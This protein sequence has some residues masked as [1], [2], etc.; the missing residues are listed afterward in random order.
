MQY[1]DILDETLYSWRWDDSSNPVDEF[2]TYAGSVDLSEPDYSFDIIG[3]WVRKSDGQVLYATDS[4]CSCPSPW[5]DTKVGDLKETTA[6]RVVDL[7]AECAETRYS[8]IPTATV[9]QSAREV[10]RRIVELGGK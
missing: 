7:A 1:E 5:E 6:D 3:F 2:L 4:G 9:R 8:P 10:Q